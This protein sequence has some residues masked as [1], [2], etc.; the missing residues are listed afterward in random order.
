MANPKGY[1]ATPNRALDDALR[2]ALRQL[3]RRLSE[4]EDYELKRPDIELI[5]AGINYERMRSRL[6]EESPGAWF[7]GGS[8]GDDDEELD[9]Q[10]EE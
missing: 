5:N 2:A 8:A 3:K 6:N 7:Q 10:L 4:N 9:K 1:R